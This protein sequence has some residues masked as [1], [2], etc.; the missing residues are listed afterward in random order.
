MTDPNATD[1]RGKVRARDRDTSWEAA[2]RQTNG[3]VAE[4]QAL[5]YTA[6]QKYGP[7]TDEE[8]ML[9]LGRLTPVSPSSLR[10]RRHELELM[11]WV[12]NYVAPA[13]DPKSP[14][15]FSDRVVKRRTLKGS[16]STVWRAVRD[17]EP[18]PEPRTKATPSRAKGDGQREHS[19]ER[20]MTAA[21]AVAQWEIGDA[22]QATRI[23]RAYLDPE[24]E[25]ARL[26]EEMDS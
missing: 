19:H 25:L 15:G 4:L 12:T 10:T 17:N 22:S 5:I 23:V 21:R 24:G 26:R 9:K 1:H 20:G 2:S 13:V 18:A 7:M 14:T 16:P 6:L 8:L 11:G 3:K